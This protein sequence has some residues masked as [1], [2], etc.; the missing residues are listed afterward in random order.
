M[1]GPDDLDRRFARGNRFADAVRGRQRPRGPL[2]WLLLGV[3]SLVAGAIFLAA[4]LLPAAF[5]WSM[6]ARGVAGPRWGLLAT[7]S[8]VALLYAAF[9][10]SLFRGRARRG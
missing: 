4:L 3:V 9:L 6:L 8:F 10:W 5:A 7:G 1:S 2:G